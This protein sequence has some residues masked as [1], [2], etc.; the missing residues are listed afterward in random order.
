MNQELI[1]EILLKVLE[2][3]SLVAIGAILHRIYYIGK[4]KETKLVKKQAVTDPLTGRGNRH[5]FISVLDKLIMKKKKF[6]VCFMDLDGFKQINDTM[7]HDAGDELLIALANTFETK[8]PKNAVAYRLGG[9]EFG[10]IIQDIKTTEDITTLLD[11]LKNEFRKPFMID[12]TAISLEYS[13]GISVFPEDAT[14]RQELIMYADDAMYYIKENGKNDYYFHNKVLRAKLENKNKM[15]NDLKLAY[16]NNQ[17]DINLQPRISIDDTSNICLESLLYWKHPVLGNISAEY[18]IKQAEEMSLI[19]KLD[20]YVLD[21]VCNKLDKIK[22]SGAKN[23]K[24]AVNISNRHVVKKDFIDKLCEILNKHAIE[25]GEI[26][27][28]FTGNI[29]EKYIENYKVMFEKLK[30]SG[31][32]IV[33]SNFEI[34]YEVLKLF[35]QLPI[36]EIKLSSKFYEKD[37]DLKK[38]VLVD[39]IKLS[40]DLGFKVVVGNIE[41][42]EELTG[43]IKSNADKIQGDLLFKRMDENVMY[44][45]IKEYTNYKYKI[46]DIIVTSK[47]KGEKK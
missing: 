33:I 5:L 22:E 38:E 26:Y 42:E 19:I 1:R 6:A 20:H 32:N 43:V 23:V 8:L 2:V 28:E 9:D 47:K 7:G 29:Q 25:P 36:D 21:L 30:Q 3:F 14:T 37:N 31:A 16:E 46:D 12:N 10:I 24:M 41:T 39:L 11:D 40:H 34:K 44:D 27:L 45:F 15:E 13:L 35:K 17:F 4:N 18:F